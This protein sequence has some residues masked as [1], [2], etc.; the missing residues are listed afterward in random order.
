MRKLSD[1][2]D[3]AFLDI[4]QEV[5]ASGSKK[6]TEGVCG[7]FLLNTDHAV[8]FQ[9]LVDINLFEGVNTDCS[10]R[11]ASRGE[12]LRDTPFRIESTYIR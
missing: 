9:Q 10:R 5:G 6:S 4:R 3:S 12:G 2:L 8:Y 1:Q 11:G 7:N